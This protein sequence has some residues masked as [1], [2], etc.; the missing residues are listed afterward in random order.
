MGEFVHLHLHS[1]YSLLDGA[2]RI[3]EIADKAIR[4]NQDAVAITDHGVMY[5]A[6]EFY[7]SLKA[8]GVKP[9]IGCEVYVAPR[10]RF[11]KEGRSDSSGDHLV[12]LCKDAVGY[13]NLCELVS[14]SFTEGFYTRPRIDMELLSAHSEGLIALSACIAGKIPSLILAGSIDEAEK[15]AL[16]MKRLF[17]EDFYLEVQNHGMEDERKV[18]FALRM[19]SEKC[20]IPLVA[21]NDVHYIEKADAD[22]QTAL[23]C[24][25]TGSTL[26]EGKPLG[27]ES[28]TYY[29]RSTEEMKA[30]FSAFP[31]AIENT[32]RIAEKCNFDFEFGKLHLPYFKPEDGLSHKEKLKRDAYLGLERHVASGRIGFERYDKQTYLDRLEYELSV[33]DTM[34]FNA[35]FLIVSDFVSY[36][37]SKDIPVGP[38]RGSGAGSLVAFCVGITDV[39]PITYDLLFERFLNPERVSMPDF[40]IDFCY[41]RREEVIAY[42][43]DKYGSDKVAQIVTFGTL[44]AR[45]V[46][47]DVGRVMGLPYSTV[48]TVA[49]LIPRELNVTLASAM[50]R[51]ELRAMYEG[52]PE[53]RK[54]LEISERLEG[55]PRH[56]STHAAGVVITELP[57]HNYV[58]LSGTNGNAVTQFDM[59][60]V[61]D[62]G[63]VK[64]DFLGL[65]YL[66]VIHDAE[67]AVR[68]RI[69]NF[70]IANVPE[71]DAATFRL[72]CHGKTDGV[73]QLESQGMK[74]VLA[75]LAPGNLEDII[76][77]IALYRPGPMD[78]I[79]TFIAR[80]HGKEKI[81]YKIEALSEILDVTYGCIVY[82]EQVM[83]I[84]RRLA[85]YSY[86]QADIV[87]RAMSKKKESVLLAEKERF[88]KGCS[89]NG[90]ENPLAEEVFDDM[91][92][93]AK[94]AFNK[95]H[96]TAYGVLSY[97]TAYLKAHYPAEYFSALLTS[98][99]SATDKLRAYI[100]DAQKHGISVLA[101]HI[102][103]SDADF[104]VVDGR[105][106]FGLLAVRN[107]G[108]AFAASVVEARRQGRFS[109]LDD[110]VHRLG[111]KELN[112]RTLES[113]I[114]CGAFDGLG[115]TRASM[116]A[117]YENIL[118]TEQERARNNISGQMDLFSMTT[119]SASASDA[120]PY[121]EIE[122]YPLKE[123]LIL[124]KESSGMYFSGHM[125]D[126]YSRHI[127]RIQVDQVADILA[128]VSE[129]SATFETKYKDRSNV[130]IA[131]IISSVRK[132]EVKN[133]DKMAFLRIDDKSGELEVIVFSRQYAAFASLISEE[134]GVLI[135]GTL[136]LEE[137]EGETNQ[138]RVL[139][140]SISLL[141]NNDAVGVQRS[142]VKTERQA[143][144][145]R[146]CIK[147]PS[148]P[149][150]RTDVLLRL[151]SLNPGKS[152]I[153]LYDASAKRYSRMQGIYMEASEKVKQRLYSLFGE[154]NVVFLPSSH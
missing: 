127:G 53:I 12:L 52:S 139:L 124:E 117:C 6:V 38:G 73:F 142:A 132:K 121:P 17:G 129:E 5:G 9:I 27:F 99:L 25:Q 151:S 89:A 15:Y 18:A 116:L 102:N 37:K 46:V 54:L 91:V 69:P 145:E 140:S 30:L 56:A 106:R 87:R 64:F 60:T 133:G 126:N 149:D 34:G 88:V 65:R 19:L 33:I 86:A 45:A 59:T 50:Q 93:F 42:V 115:A 72:L 130:K 75:R 111:G 41:D 154:E 13:R 31:G 141:E 7:R 100:D 68:R 26:A 79:G 113:L 90:I 104:S 120:Y 66:T 43:K 28:E 134:V 82:Q 114:K 21:T 143:M 119:A 2:S 20:N 105:I 76:A 36:A 128:D 137:G 11:Q 39:D 122:E 146:I 8:K 44:A 24:I 62:L 22:M 29:F 32:V 110:F 98:V 10:S 152:E 94:Y 51:K 58:P 92:S 95:S 16:E 103:E 85:G 35:Y 97:R 67:R 70:D 61:A 74:A 131:G 148:L 3:S 49:K 108:R 48:D 71:D 57:L 153:L 147:L 136:S 40:D 83:Q 80:K 14:K 144:A 150:K 109:S 4:E 112:R 107:V 77:T 123:L 118:D 23:L 125:L 96:A 135:E 81:S 101:P 84:F 55:M 63:L 138:V 1:E 47:R 78:S